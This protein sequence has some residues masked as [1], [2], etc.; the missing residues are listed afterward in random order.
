MR[1]RK[2]TPEGRAQRWAVLRRIFPG[3]PHAPTL[4][5]ALRRCCDL[6]DYADALACAWTALCIAAGDAV[7]MPVEPPRD[8]K[9]LRMTIWRPA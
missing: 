9:G 2:S 7:S 6:E 5:G 4:P 8:A 1:H 3:L